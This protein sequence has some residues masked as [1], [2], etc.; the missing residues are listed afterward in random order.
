MTIDYI[1][2]AEIMGRRKRWAR[3]LT[4]GE[5]NQ[6]TGRLLSMPSGKY[7]CL[8][9]ACSV[10]KDD[11]GI[12]KRLPSEFQVTAAMKFDSEVGASFAIG[13]DER[14]LALPEELRIYLGLSVND[15]NVLVKLNDGGVSFGVIASVIMEMAISRD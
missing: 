13:E 4:S 14:V 3:A 6:G 10:F 12:E 11:L 15:Q 9:V 8:G 2:I 7:C 5:Y 1:S